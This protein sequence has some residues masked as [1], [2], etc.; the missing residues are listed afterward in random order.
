MTDTTTQEPPPPQRAPG[1]LDDLF[2]RLRGLG[3]RRDTDRR[4]FGGVCSGIAARVDVD[5][6]LIRAAAIA[7]TIAGGFGIALY[8]VLWFV[9]PD[10]HDRVLAE[11]ALRQG[12]AWPVV[13]GVAAG[14]FVVGGLAS[15]GFGNDGIGSS[16]WIV[17][18]VALVVWFL[19]TRSRPGALAPWPGTGPAR[20]VPPPPPPGTPAP[21]GDD[22]VAGPTPGGPPMSAPTSS[23]APG[24][25]DTGAPST[26]APAGTPPGGPGTLARGPY[27]G[28]RP[29]AAPVPPP[30]P[31]PRRRRPSGFV[32]LVSLGVAIVLGGLGTLLAGPVGFPGEPAVLGIVLALAGVSA[33]VVG[34]G[35]S[36]RAAGFSGFLVVVLA[37][38]GVATAAATQAVD[39]RGGFGDRTWTPM[40]S[41]LPADY[42][43]GAG[44]AVLDLRQLTAPPD[45]APAGEVRASLGAGQLDIRVPA[46]LTVEI[47][48][49]TGL[50]RIEHD[51]TTASGERRSDVLQDGTDRA[52]RVVTGDG[53]EPD[54]VVSVQL[55]FG[56]ITIDEEG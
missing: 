13:L 35:L 33:V 9:L 7:L 49:T 48:P 5:P 43:L 3:L 28:A 19:A 50:G 4:W 39:A 24:T 25:L 41:G 52:P 54:L 37:F 31:R 46:D 45:G 16:L 2:S 51:Y 29:P 56:D 36:G 23:F 15:V 14:L 34:L 38:L 47:V 53:G 12:E 40:T 30:P 27:G 26:A 1:A 22:T 18:P 11:R 55:G 20:A 21:V 32:G 6:L 10:R 17:L 42:E 8:L 44:D